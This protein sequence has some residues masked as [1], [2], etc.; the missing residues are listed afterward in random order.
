MFWLII[1]I[2][3][4]IK[5]LVEM[6]NKPDFLTDPCF[7]DRSCF[8]SLVNS[9]K[10]RLHFS[11]FLLAKHWQTL[12]DKVKGKPCFSTW[13]GFGRYIQDMEL[14]SI[15]RRPFHESDCDHVG[16]LLQ[17][18]RHKTHSDS[19][20]EIQRATGIWVMRLLAILTQRLSL[21]TI[22]CLRDKLRQMTDWKND[23]KTWILLTWLLW[24]TGN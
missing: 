24:L 1:L 10:L 23:C 22:S 4:S 19:Q 5:Y 18:H 15:G 13:H 16:L 17:T 3:C 8:L 9:C 14:N 6:K 12:Q 11:R 21:R 20:T 7:Y 2:F